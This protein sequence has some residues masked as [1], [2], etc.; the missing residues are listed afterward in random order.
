[1]SQAPGD[2][3]SLP[4]SVSEDTD[5]G[6]NLKKIIIV[7][8]I[9]LVVFAFSAVL[10]W[11]ILAAD[12]NAIRQERGIAEPPSGLQKLQE[13]GLVDVTHFD[14]DK[15]LELWKAAKAKQAASYGWV[16]RAKGVVHIPIEEAMKEVVRQAQSGGAAPAAGGAPR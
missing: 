11:W 12:T 4:H 15:R 7:G 10:A 16:D 13:V 2:I 6:I 9:S 5:D 8:V 3:H 14:D 1:M